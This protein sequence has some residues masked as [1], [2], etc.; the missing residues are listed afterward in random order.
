MPLNTKVISTGNGIELSSINR[1]EPSVVSSVPGFDI[2]ENDTSKIRN[3]TNAYIYDYRPKVPHINE[4]VLSSFGNK[5][6]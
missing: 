5:R 3:S 6:R 1:L 2:R 4:P